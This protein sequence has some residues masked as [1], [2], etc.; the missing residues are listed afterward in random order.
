MDAP[1]TLPPSMSTLYSPLSSQ[2]YEPAHLPTSSVS[3][4]ATVTYSVPFSKKPKLDIAFSLTPH[5]GIER[6]L[7]PLSP[8]YSQ[9]HLLNLELLGHKASS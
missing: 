7:S 6:D 3:V 5:P 8:E 2:M 1:P 4:N 9:L